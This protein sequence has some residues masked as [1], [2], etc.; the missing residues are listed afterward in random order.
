MTEERQTGKDMEGSKCG[1]MLRYYPGICLEGLMKT[2]KTISQD[3]RYPGRDLNLGTPEYEAGAV[4][5]RPPRSVEDLY[6]FETEVN[7]E[8]SVTHWHKATAR[9]RKITIR[10]TKRTCYRGYSRKGHSAN[11]NVVI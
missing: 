5:T 9:R 4:I 11:D 7:L 8:L 3:N 10:S 6:R 2:T 1:L